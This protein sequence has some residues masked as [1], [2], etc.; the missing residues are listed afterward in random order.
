MVFLAG[1]VC[2]LPALAQYS[3]K[4][5]EKKFEIDFGLGFPDLL[6]A[7]MKYKLSESS[8]IGMSY[9]ALIA[10]G[11]SRGRRMSAITLEH[12]YHFGKTSG[13]SSMPL[14][15]FGQKL[16]YIQDVDE[17]S[18]SET[19]Y[20]TPYIGKGFYS[21]GPFGINIDL[22]LNFKIHDQTMAHIESDNRNASSSFPGVFPAM[23][24]Q[25][26]FEF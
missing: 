7:G 8:K 10:P 15:F 3:S 22:G 6:H 11:G 9:G 1:M 16:T 19:V 13:K 20:F 12:E 21:E 25:F 26:F 4:A 18:S 23:R 24:L 14:Y 2:C 5:P 17:L